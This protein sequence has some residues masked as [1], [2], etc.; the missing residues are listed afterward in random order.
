ML[1][2]FAWIRFRRRAFRLQNVEWDFGRSQRYFL[3]VFKIWYVCGVQES[4]NELQR[5]QA[6]LQALEKEE[7]G[8]GAAQ[9]AAR[10]ARA[11]HERRARLLQRALADDDAARS[12]KRAALAQVYIIYRYVLYRNTISRMLNRLG[13]SRSFHAC[14]F[15]LYVSPW[16]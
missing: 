6:E 4:G 12:A 16:Q 8:A 14:C 5:L 13:L 3:V 1:E 7:A 15:F 10:D 9:R 2:L 11:E